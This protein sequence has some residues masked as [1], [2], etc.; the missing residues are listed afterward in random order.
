MAAKE[1]IFKG[2]PASKGISMGKPFLY[3][4]EKPAN[5]VSGNGDVSVEKEVSEYKQAIAQSVKELNKIFS[6]AK[7]KLDAK[8]LQIFDAQLLF[9]KDEVL[10][11]QVVKRI[12]REHK[13]AY[14]SFSDVI[15]VY[16]D[17]FLQ[18]LKVFAFSFF[19]FCRMF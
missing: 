10:F 5:I 11:Q 4:V 3:V 19:P 8:N 13:S 18:R 2:L 7:E 1:E 6:L 14:Q 17:N 12:R 15:K 9:L 16:E